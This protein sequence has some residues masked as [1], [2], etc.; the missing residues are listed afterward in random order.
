MGKNPSHFSA[1]GGGSAKVTGLTTTDFPVDTVSWEDAKDFCD[2]LSALA[3]E[4]KAGRV[5]RLPTEAEW[6]YA[7]RAGT[8]TTFHY[9]NSLGGNDAN[10]DGTNPYGGALVGPNL[11]RT[12]KVGSY[13]PNTW[14]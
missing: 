14:G 8:T 6:E 2:K 11:Q 7:C 9:G 10:C 4:K 1:T 3:D 5:Y 13:K 12:A